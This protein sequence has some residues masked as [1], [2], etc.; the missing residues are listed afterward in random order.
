MIRDQSPNAEKET[1]G[2]GG[3]CWVWCWADSGV[4]LRPP[5]RLGDN[6]SLAWRA[7]STSDVPRHRDCPGS[8]GR[9]KLAM[10]V[11][12]C[13]E[14]GESNMTFDFIDSC[15]NEIGREVLCR[16]A[17]WVVLSV[18]WGQYLLCR[19]HCLL[20]TLYGRAKGALL[21]V[22]SVCNASEKHGLA[23]DLKIAHA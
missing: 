22:M 6:I 12:R 4:L 18:R 17:T 3:S 7:G 2:E 14:P 21:Y 13:Q 16:L 19:A 23:K 15:T 5:T 8:Q 20:S 9:W 10:C 11:Y 1:E